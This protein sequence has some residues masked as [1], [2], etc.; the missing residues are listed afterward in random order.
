MAVTVIVFD[1]KER[2]IFAMIHA[3]GEPPAIPEFPF[4]NQLTEMVPEPPFAEPVRSKVPAVVESGGVF[5]V[6][7]RAVGGGSV[8]IPSCAV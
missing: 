2:G 3:D 6:S 7:V 1:P 4:A 5:T 8:N